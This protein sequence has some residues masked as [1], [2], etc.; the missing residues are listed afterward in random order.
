MPPRL[1]RRRPLA[2]RLRAYLDPAD[3]LIWL[4]EEVDSG[5]WDTWQKDWATVIGIGLNLLFLVARS[6]VG[7]SSKSYDDVFGDEQRSNS[8][9]AWPVCVHHLQA[10][11]TFWKHC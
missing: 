10:E 11:I 1:I 9:L 2:E 7:H 4:S 6:N 5:D 3:F 8:W